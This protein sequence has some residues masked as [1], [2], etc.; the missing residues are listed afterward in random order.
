MNLEGG[1]GMAVEK[2]SISNEDLEMINKMSLKEFGKDDVFVFRFV[3][4]DNQI[5]R[6]HERFDD[7]V[8]SQM[9]KLYVGTTMIKDHQPRADNQVARIYRAETKS[10]DNGLVELICYAYVPVIDSTKDFI[11]EIESGLKKEISV[12]CSVGQAICS[13]CGDDKC[14]RHLK[15]K[16]YNGVR[17]YRT[18][19][20]LT[21]VYEIS[22]VAVPAQKNAGV[23]K[24]YKNNT[25]DQDLEDELIEYEL[26]EFERMF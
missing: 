14:G 20:N 9:A 21:D 18:L 8:L 11:E 4:C 6:D 22:F 3:A 15:G 2:I 13:V 23:I 26:S 24:Q 12:S 1:E 7:S 16:S 19:K 17:C 10:G 25:N 5:D